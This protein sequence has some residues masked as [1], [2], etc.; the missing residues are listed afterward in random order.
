M[1]K[2]Q[3]RRDFIKLL[4]KGSI[5][6]FTLSALGGC[7]TLLQAIRNR[8]VRRDIS[9]LSPTDPIIQTYKDAVDQMKSMDSSDPSN[10][11]NWNNQ[12]QIHFNHCPHGNWYFLP[13]H[14]AYLYH[15]E[16]IC[17]EL[18]GNENFALPYW[19]WTKDK[20]IPSVFWGG[21]SNPL[22]N[23]SRTATSGSTASDSFIGLPV[24]ESI[25]NETNFLLYASG[26]STTLRGDPATMANL[27]RRRTTIYTD[28]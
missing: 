6:L 16:Q 24:V 15:F 9:G 21:S 28:L 23:A 25:Q 4:S 26:Q 20:Q 18:T 5:S 14:R 19:N 7:E 12:A 2:K 13:W 8:P 3:T 11:R 1:K 27:S 10:P 17:R 22:F